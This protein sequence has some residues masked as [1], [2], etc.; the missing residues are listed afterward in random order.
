MDKLL[1]IGPV[2]A[3]WSQMRY[4]ENTLGFLKS[5]YDT[6]FLD[7]LEDITIARNRTIFFEAWREKI[8]SVLV[9]YDLLIGF[10]L[11]GL[12]LQEC[13]AQILKSKERKKIIFFS[14]PSF[15][16]EMLHTRL[17][18]VIQKINQLGI[19]S[20]MHAKNEYVFSPYSVTGNQGSVA[21]PALASLRL[22][23]GLEIILNTDSR[24]LL[25]NK[26]VPYLHFIGEKSA[27]IN[28]NNVIHPYPEYLHVVPAASMRV[29]QDNPKYCIHYIQKYIGIP[30]EVYS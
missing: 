1:V 10:S 3:E 5:S 6:T 22:T 20:G 7:P 18:T 4:I 30:E 19:H 25:M 16:D 29:L 28:H 26:A 24:R 15:V 23:R 17:N 14:V 12:I 13:F 8:L 21:D 11:G 27:L 9:N 2:L